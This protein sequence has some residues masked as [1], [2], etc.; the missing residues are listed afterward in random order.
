M[1]VKQLIKLLQAFDPKTKVLIDYDPE[2]GWYDAEAV[3][4]VHEGKKNYVNIVS[5]NEA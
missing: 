1:T 4:E 3:E 2:S 5:S